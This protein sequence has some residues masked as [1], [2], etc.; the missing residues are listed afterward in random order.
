MATISTTRHVGYGRNSTKNQAGLQST[1]GIPRVDPGRARSRPRIDG[2]GA[3]GEH[4]GMHG[5]ISPWVVAGRIIS[6]IGMSCAAAIGI[7]GLVGP[8]WAWAIF[9]AITLLAVLLADRLRRALLGEAGVDWPGG[10]RLDVLGTARV[11]PTKRGPPIGCGLPHRRSCSNDSKTRCLSRRSKSG[12]KR[13]CWSNRAAVTQQLGSVPN[14]CLAPKRCGA[15]SWIVL[16]DSR[17]YSGARPR[18]REP[19]RPSSG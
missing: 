6:I 2:G 4:G 18:L 11:A 9:G 8:I 12:A 17:G 10:S 13:D 3:S 19:R 14:L 16:V 15:P 5:P 7:L 1:S